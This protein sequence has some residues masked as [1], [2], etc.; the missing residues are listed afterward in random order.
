MRIFSLASLVL[1]SGQL[2]AS[3]YD[4]CE[5]DPCC[6]QQF[7]VDRCQIFISAEFLY[8]TVEEGALDYAI[9][10]NQPAWGPTPAFATGKYEI[11]DYDWRP[12]YRVSLAWYNH[13][14]Y[15]EIKAE[16]TWL[17]DKGSDTTNDPSSPDLFVNSTWNTITSDPLRK[18]SSLIDLTRS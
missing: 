17:Y 10:M 11:A 8:W 9:K 2:L 13:P 14:K 6:E 12:G 4:C 7:F 16:Y 15:W 5:P 1:C 18:A 3:Q